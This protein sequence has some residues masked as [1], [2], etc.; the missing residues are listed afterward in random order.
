MNIFIFRF[1]FEGWILPYSQPEINE[2]NRTLYHHGEESGRPGYTLQ[3]LFQLSRY[4][5]LNNTIKGKFIIFLFFRSSVIQQKIIAINTI[6]NILA[7]NSTG[8]Y[9]GIIDVP[10][11][12]IFFV[13]RFCLDDNTPGVLNA[14]IKAMRNLIF[15]QVDE[16][17][18]DSLLGK[19]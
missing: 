17:C 5:K 6:A 3:E 8:I 7:L 19:K 14:S 10:I 9:D 18:L 1:D 2:K 12:Q 11:E 15:S 13:I 16:T 4:Q